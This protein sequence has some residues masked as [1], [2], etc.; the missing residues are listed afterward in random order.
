MCVII[1]DA[2][3]LYFEGTHAKKVLDT[4]SVNSFVLKMNLF[5]ENWLAKSV[6]NGTCFENDKFT[7]VSN[8][9]FTMIQVCTVVHY[10]FS[11]KLI[12]VGL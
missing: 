8:H 12:A 5:F 11:N 2:Q 6:G 1:V 9:Y 3:C 7:H 10:S 4:S